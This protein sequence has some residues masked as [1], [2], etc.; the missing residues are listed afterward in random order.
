MII[1]R[2]YFFL[3]VAVIVVMVV[4]GIRAT[5]EKVETNQSGQ[6]SA[7]SSASPQPERFDQ[8]AFV[9]DT[10][11]NFSIWTNQNMDEEHAKIILTQAEEL[12][13]HYEQMMSK[14]IE[15]SDVYR[16]NHANGQEI[17]VE[18]ETAALIQKSIEYSKLSDGYFDITI[19]PVK[20]LWDFK[21]DNPTVPTQEQIDAAKK[22]VNYKN[23]FVGEESKDSS[24]NVVGVNVKLANGAM[25]DLGGIAKRYIADRVAEMMQAEGVT[26]GIVNLGG[27]VLMIGEKEPGVPW[28][29]GIQDPSGEQNKYITTV[30]IVGESVVTSGVYE[31]YFEK[32]GVIYHHLLDPFTGRPVENGLVS[33]SIIAESSVDCDALS[34]TC[35]VLGE[36]KGLALIE[37]L[38]EVEA[39]FVE[40]SG[41]MV[42]SSG[43]DRYLS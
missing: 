28:S 41:E 37:S 32:D 2:K 8:T 33:V 1:N 10:V 43:M 31:R 22:L 14:S 29:V 16:L 11:V 15:T 26:K 25:I 35:F 24:G 19:L 39:I 5:S 40:S 7:A 38:A 20:E 42:Y 27:N 3:A 13:K 12:C 36:E 17:L 6:T 4:F 23:I 21:A 34:T 18:P 30:K 9:L